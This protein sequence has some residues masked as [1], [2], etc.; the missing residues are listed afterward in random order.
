M[1][2]LVVALALV[3]S[4]C[5]ADSGAADAEPS[6]RVDAAA[7][8][9][10]KPSA[11]KAVA[12]DPAI[13]RQLVE[14]HECHR[15]HEATG[16]EPPP[17]S[18]QCV[19]CH[20]AILAGDFE[21]SASDMAHWKR[22][23]V[24]LRR[25]PSLEGIGKLMKASWIA[26]LLQRPHDLRPNLPATM[27]RMDIDPAS[28]RHIAAYLTQG[29]GPRGKPPRGDISK[30]SALFEAKQCN[31]CH[32]DKESADPRRLDPAVLLA[33]SLRHT[34]ERMHPDVVAS[35]I[36]DP[37]AHK[38]DALMP[39]TP[40][41]EDEAEDLASFVLRWPL[42]PAA[43]VAVPARLPVLEREV[44]Y[45]EVEKRVFKKVCWHCHSQPDFARGDGGPGMSGGFGFAGRKLD[46]SSYG[47]IAG[48]YLDDDGE[49]ASAFRRSSDGV[50]MLVAVMLA[51]QQEEA[52]KRPKLRGMPL[53]LPAMTPEE[54]QLVETWIAQGRPQ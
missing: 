35:F 12:P 50:P 9:T 3:L 29:S 41:T 1:R 39:K 52:G 47:S 13:G 51:R 43:P 46:L 36:R 14:K 25:V 33:P 40:L 45:E 7:P 2:A 31:S 27:P 17:Q 26:E 28:A 16:L 4:A 23:I 15:C 5:N 21:A 10:G 37:L 32:A 11:A 19:G 6:A 18:K 44:T 38:S 53:G 34:R 22:N 8:A 42:R 30:G 20:R 24:H 54:V 48:G 49:M